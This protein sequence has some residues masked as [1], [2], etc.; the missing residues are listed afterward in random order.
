MDD[1][2]QGGPSLTSPDSSPCSTSPSHLGINRI[3]A[4]EIFS[5]SATF[6][7]VARAGFHLGEFSITHRDGGVI[8]ISRAS[9]AWEMFRRAISRLV[10]SRNV[11]TKSSVYVNMILDSR[12]MQPPVKEPEGDGEN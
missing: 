6:W 9:L 2:A 7:T 3:A 11:L 5:A 4:G 12:L 8:P 1:A 10:F